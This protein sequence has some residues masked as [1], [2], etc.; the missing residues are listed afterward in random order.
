[1]LELNQ[2][3]NMD[4]MKG[5]PKNIDSSYTGSGALWVHIP[6]KPPYFVDSCKALSGCKAGQVNLVHRHTITPFRGYFTML[7]TGKH[8]RRAVWPWLGVL[9][10]AQVL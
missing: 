3:Y 7:G 6:R 2:C 5:I 1:M 9:L 8:P 10:F 4:C